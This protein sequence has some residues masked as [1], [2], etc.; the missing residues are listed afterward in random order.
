MK[1][2]RIFPF[3]LATAALAASAH[4]DIVVFS[5]GR[6]LK[7][8][9]YKATE[10]RMELTLPSGGT[11]FV[12]L[13]RV[14]RVVDDEVVPEVVVEEVREVGEFPHRGWKFDEAR[15]PL[16]HSRYDEL[17]TRVSRKYDVD[18]SLVSAVI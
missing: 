12:P 4:A 13:A 17:I 8:S 6:T 10:E 9:G 2:S 1:I 7:V 11:M 16:F 15:L 18:A 14:E 5:N 3:V